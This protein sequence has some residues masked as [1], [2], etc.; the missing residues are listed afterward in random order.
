MMRRHRLRHRYGRA[1][2]G[3]I[4]IW[5]APEA[6]QHKATAQRLL[7][8]GHSYRH[9]GVDTDNCGFCALTHGGLDGP[10]YAGWARIYIEAGKAMPEKWRGAFERELASDNHHY[11]V[12]LRRSIATFGGPKF[13]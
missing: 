6:R 7:G 2:N 5:T 10:N 9:T 3:V 11:A 13:R 12:A 4:E 8:E 1:G